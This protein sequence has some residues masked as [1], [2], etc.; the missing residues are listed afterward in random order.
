MYDASL[1]LC[2]FLRGICSTTAFPPQDARLVS[3]E[4]GS[5]VVKPRSTNKPPVME[6]GSSCYVVSINRV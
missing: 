3:G 6:C 1:S 2:F 5:P 4:I